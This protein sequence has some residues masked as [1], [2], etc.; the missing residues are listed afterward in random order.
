MHNRHSQHSPVASCALIKCSLPYQ[1][2]RPCLERARL[3]LIRLYNQRKNLDRLIYN[4]HTNAT[5]LTSSIFRSNILLAMTM[6]AKFTLMPQ[7]RQMSNFVTMWVISYSSV[8]SLRFPLATLYAQI[9]IKPCFNPIFT[10]YF[11]R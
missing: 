10:I 6:L 11:F 7:I 2:V 5:T 8:S 4:C 3:M 1:I 9:S